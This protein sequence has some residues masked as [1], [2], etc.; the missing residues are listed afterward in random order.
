MGDYYAH[1]RKLNGHYHNYMNQTNQ[2]IGITNAGFREFAERMARERILREAQTNRA[3]LSRYEEEFINE[4]D[5]FYTKYGNDMIDN[6]SISYK[7]SV[8]KR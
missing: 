7:T 1:S 6:G 8:Q 5:L 3:R 4:M 2:P